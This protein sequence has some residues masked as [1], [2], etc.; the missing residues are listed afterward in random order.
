MR[1]CSLIY[2]II[3]KQSFCANIKYA[4]AFKEFVLGYMSIYY[5]LVK[6]TSLPRK[7]IRIRLYVAKFSHRQSN[8][9]ILLYVNILP[10]AI[11]SGTK[12]ELSFSW[13]YVRLHAVYFLCI[14][15]SNFVKLPGKYCIYIREDIFDIN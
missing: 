3:L 13:C 7:K 8:A 12:S 1:M 14:L 9:H 10:C 6:Q 11:L 15:I 5:F 2:S 4:W